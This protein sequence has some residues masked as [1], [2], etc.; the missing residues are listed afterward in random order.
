MRVLHLVETVL[1]LTVVMLSSGCSAPPKP[2]EFFQPVS[3][4]QQQVTSRVFETGNEMAILRACANVL[5]DN[6]FQL[7]EAESRLGWMSA[8][9]IKFIPLKMPGPVSASATVF[10]YPAAGRPGKSI[11]RLTLHNVP[12]ADIYQELFARIAQTLFVKAQPL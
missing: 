9:K 3:L 1:A 6:S 5:M 10:V 4:Q 7:Y 12:D 2:A 8:R 11:V